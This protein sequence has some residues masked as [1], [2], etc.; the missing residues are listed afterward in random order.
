MLFKSI[1]QKHICLF[2]NNK[3][4]E[5]QP[6][7]RKIHYIFGGGGNFGSR[8]GYSANIKQIKKLTIIYRLHE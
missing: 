4:L 6:E 2:R 1:G 3:C 7:R 8:F 5:D